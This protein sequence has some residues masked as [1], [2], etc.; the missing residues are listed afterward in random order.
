[1]YK[2]NEKNY[3]K[4][5][6]THF[7]S[8]PNSPFGNEVYTS[9]K[10]KWLNRV[11]ED[12]LPVTK[13]AE[14]YKLAK[15]SE[16]V[17]FKNNP[18]YFEIIAGREK[19]SWGLNG[20]G[21]IMREEYRLPERDIPIKDYRDT[22]S[23]WNNYIDWDHQCLGYDNILKYGLSGLKNKAMENL[24]KYDDLDKSGVKNK[25]A[26]LNS[27][28]V[29]IDSVC[30]I[31]DKFSKKAKEMLKAETDKEVIENLTLIANTACDIPKNP[32]K[33]F[34][35]A[36]ATIFFMREVATSVDGVAV[37]MFGMIDRML[38]PYYEADLKSGKITKKEAKELLKAFLY[39]TDARFDMHSGNYET[40]TTINIGGQDREGNIIFNDITKM[41]C[42]IFVELNIIGV[43]LDARITKSHPKEY[44]DILANLLAKGV[45]S[46]VLINDEALVA[47]HVF[48]GKNIKD[49][50]LI[51]TGGCQEPMLAN[52]ELNFKAFVY[53]NLV[54]VFENTFYLQNYNSFEEFYSELTKELDDIYVILA[55]GIRSGAK[56]APITNPCPL[57]S[58][59]IDNCIENGKDIFEGGAKYNSAS[60]AN[61]GLGTLIDSV[62]AVKYLVFD[63]KIV[64]FKDLKTALENDFN[65]YEDILNECKNVPKYGSEDADVMK[66]AKQ[67]T[68]DIVRLSS[69][70]DNGRGGVTE[71]SFFTYYHF[72]SWG[73]VIG[74]TPDG[75]HAGEDLSRGVSP[76]E[77]NMKDITSVIN[78]N[79]F[80]PMDKA[81]GCAI[82]EMTLQEAKNIDA[83]SALMK[84]FVDKKGNMLQMS[85]VDREKLL[86]ARIN[87]EKYRNLSV[88]M[89]G[90][91]AYFTALPSELQEE[92]IRRA[93]L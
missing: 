30:E 47:S 68:D 82:L 67:I 87:P 22:I 63:K 77:V 90:Y 44:F 28:I 40:S 70:R 57:L 80:L 15:E 18:F 27:V 62:Y 61:N 71:P 65:G 74:A 73:K 88:R 76:S 78:D 33:T 17:I 53:L 23:T 75:R 1:M 93:V 72:H 10:E 24:A 56:E 55:E 14:L 36:L 49:A 50:R 45:N 84:T 38:Y 37:S 34:Y 92:V 25:V 43:K 7:A 79:T 85:L 26:F 58:S 41:I 48:M 51:V 29:A 12:M 59:T 42:E 21:A 52:C 64:S 35:E 4:E 31:A 60:I 91:S 20:I 81:P 2:F 3:V 69:G 5:Y 6:E 19:L 89:C 8:Y 66:I 39:N 9:V 86:D 54:K 16:V 13:K 83:I 11:N 46:L 32:P